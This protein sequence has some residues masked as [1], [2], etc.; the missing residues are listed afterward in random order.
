MFEEI[1]IARNGPAVTYTEEDG[2]PLRYGMTNTDVN[3]FLDGS[4]FGNEETSLNNNEPN[5]RGSEYLMKLKQ[6]LPS[7][8]DEFEYGDL[9]RLI[10]IYN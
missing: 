8:F 3:T 1:D 5:A 10:K 4:G 9:E 7:I 2:L 6:L